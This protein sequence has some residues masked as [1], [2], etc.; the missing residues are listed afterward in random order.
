MP[1]GWEKCYIVRKCSCGLTRC[2]TKVISWTSLDV[3]INL[4]PFYVPAWLKYSIG[5]D[6]PINDLE[7][8]QNMIEYRS[9]DHVVADSAFKKLSSHKWYLNEET[10]AFSFFSDHRCM[11]SDVKEAMALRLLSISPPDEFR[12]GIPVCRRNVDAF[13]KVVDLIGP[14]TWFLFETLDLDRSWLYLSPE[15]WP[16]SESYQKAKTF[17]CNLKVVNDAA[18][19]NVKLYADY[20]AILTEN[21][22]T[23]GQFITSC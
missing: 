10:V 21:E 8:L 18:E 2:N 6:A 14:E 22:R 13:T 1:D 5:V 11:S 17:V 23:A 3:S 9:D 7:F 20:A 16:S 12:R 15:L 19:R 4:L